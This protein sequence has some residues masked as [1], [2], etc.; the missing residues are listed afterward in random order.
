M[1]NTDTSTVKKTLI[2]VEVFPYEKKALKEHIRGKYH[3]ISD[4]LRETI[5]NAIKAE[6]ESQE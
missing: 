3:S 6:P 4:F 5:R 2:Q 1:D